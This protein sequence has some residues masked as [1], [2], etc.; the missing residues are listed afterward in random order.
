MSEQ[1]SL[2]APDQ[3][4]PDRD[5]LTTVPANADPLRLLYALGFLVLAAAIL[6]V[7]L[8]P[9]MPAANQGQ[10]SEIRS[11]EQRLDAFD[12]RLGRLEQQPAPPSAAD[13]GKISARLDVLEARVSDQTQLSTRLDGLSARIESLSGRDQTALDAIK[14]QVDGIASQVSNQEK[15]VAGVDAVSARVTRIA[16]IHAAQ[17]ALAAGQPLGTIPNAPPALARYADAAPP[18]EAQLRLAFPQIERAALT[19]AQ[20]VKSNDPFLDRAW[21]RAQALITVR[22]GDQVVVGNASAVQLDQARAALD[23]G[24]LAAAVKS[25]SAA[26]PGVQ[27]IASDWL[28]QAKSLLDAR[29]ALADLAAHS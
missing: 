9:K 1:L 7:W 22:Q 18:T 8:F 26:G 23:A 3:P 13:L 11:I 17:L 15:A 6:G 28:T 16:R 27:K 29:T 21:E 2:P 25:V 4:V 19:L 14:R 12:S 10:V 5:A 24:D 20:P